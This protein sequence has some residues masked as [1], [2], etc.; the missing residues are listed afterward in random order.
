MGLWANMRDPV[1]FKMLFIA[2]I[3]IVLLVPLFLIR[4]VI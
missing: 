2:I 3:I 1:M 4:A